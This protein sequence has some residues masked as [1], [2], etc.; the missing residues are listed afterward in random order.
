MKA[1]R[2]PLDRVLHWRTV[3]C[4]LEEAAGLRLA[5]QRSQLAEQVEQ[6][7]ALRKNAASFITDQATVEA[8]EFQT[9]ASFNV[10]AEQRKAEIRRRA[11]KLKQEADAQFVRTAEARRKKK[12]LE[13]LRESRL[14]TWTAL[15]DK[16]D[17]QAAADSWLSRYAAERYTTEN[18]S[19][20]SR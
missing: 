12:L 6:I 15:R 1:F 3:Q 10:W 17:E 9:L 13:T 5:A 19:P 4:E 11:A 14:T 2:F 18:A 8:T 20:P 7:S 16:E